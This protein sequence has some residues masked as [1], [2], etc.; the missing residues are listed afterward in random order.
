[1]TH[2]QM[3]YI[4]VVAEEKSISKAAELLYISQSALSVSIQKIEE[5]LGN[6]IFIRSNRGVELT[7]FGEEFLAYIEPLVTQ[8]ELVESIF[9]H[10]KKRLEERL[11]VAND[12]FYLV[13]N[14]I[15]H[16]VREY[17]DRSVVIEHYDTFGSEARRLVANQV[18][19][20]GVIH[21]WNKYKKVEIRQLT[22]MGLEYYP[23]TQAKLA[24]TVGKG[25]QLFHE[26]PDFV[27]A[28][29]LAV[30][31]MIK[32]GAIE[33]GPYS[34]LI[35][36]IGLDQFPCSVITNSRAVVTDLLYTTDGY[37]LDSLWSRKGPVT[38][39]ISKD[40]D[41]LIIPLL[42]DEDINSEMG[43]IKKKGSTLPSIAQEFINILTKEIL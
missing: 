39:R 6:E 7:P 40:K 5:D 22:A 15:S 33:Y 35:R 36:E 20:V 30:Y 24:V 16:I 42:T 32:Y 14:V 1:M 29:R 38:S 9:M 27:T 28:D 21:M 34:S 4:V 43:W 3:R 13:S 31:P 23:L 19:N 2:D 18:A 10:G 25:N 17:R 41:R 37:I 11:S 12:S 26:A 8:F